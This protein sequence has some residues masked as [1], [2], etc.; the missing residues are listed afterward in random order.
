MTT[1]Q[2]VSDDPT[3]GEDKPCVLIVDDSR[4]MRVALSRL[5]GKGYQVLEAED[6]QKGWDMLQAHPEIELVF[7]DLS[8]PV[9]DGFELLRRVRASVEPALGSLPFVVITGHEDDEGMQRKAVEMGASDFVSK[10]FR[11]AEITARAKN[12]TEQRRSMRELRQ[13]LDEQ[14]S[15]DAVTGL[16]NASQ[17]T[18]GFAQLLSL[19]QR[20]GLASACLLV[21]M[22]GFAQLSPEPPEHQAD[23]L[24]R[25]MA[26][27]VSEL[28]RVED[29]T[30]YLGD[31]RFVLALC[32]ADATGAVKMARRLRSHLRATPLGELPMPELEIGISMPDS[33]HAS[34]DNL[35]QTA[36]ADL[37]PL[38]H[39]PDEPVIAPHVPPGAAA[40]QAEVETPSEL[41]LLQQE[42]EQA[43]DSQLLAQQAERNQA[44][45]LRSLQEGA[46]QQLA[47]AH[48][49]IATLRTQLATVQAKF[50]DYAARYSQASQLQAEQQVAELRTALAERDKQLQAENAL[51]V[52]AQENL[53]V[54]QIKLATA[55]QPADTPAEPEPA[56][57]R[58]GRLSRLF[59]RG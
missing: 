28:T 52:E 59:G 1:E 51:R 25:A 49:I 9:V 27:L 19:S 16:A 33:E 5:L 41:L 53:K 15:V 4:V 31:G 45:Q 6:G 35:L 43:R 40:D 57:K 32:G 42:L 30:G 14:A 44:E 47:K 12:L 10:P 22:D 37:R 54:L 21:Q 50:R 58:G 38:P 3:T 29:V 34:A 20:H 18:A 13:E 8:M 23:E 24:L 36:Q 26:N 46:R 39:D 7:S 55:M 11:S 2:S 17:F 48:Q 56:H